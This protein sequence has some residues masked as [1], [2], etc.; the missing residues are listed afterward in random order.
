MSK[1]ELDFKYD[2][3]LAAYN[4]SKSLSFSDGTRKME[5]VGT[6]MEITDGSNKL[7]V[8]SDATNPS[9]ELTNGSNVM[10]VNKTEASLVV[11]TNSLKFVTGNKLKV[12]Y[13]KYNLDISKDKASYSDG[14]YSVNLGGDQLLKLNDKTKTFLV[15]NDQSVEF[16]EGTTTDIKVS[17]TGLDFKY[18]KYKASFSTSK[19]LS[20]TDGTRSFAFAGNK[21]ELKENTKILTLITDATNPSIELSD[22]SNKLKMSKTNAELIYGSNSLKIDKDAKLGIVYNGHNINVDS[23]KASYSKGSLKATVGGGNIVSVSEGNR[24]LTLTKKADIELVDGKYKA[25]LNYS[26][27]SLSLTDGTHTVKAGGKDLL[28]YSQAKYEIAFFKGASS[29]YG[30]RGKYDGTE[31]AV[32]GGKGKKVKVI[33]KNSS[34]GTLAV[35]SNIKKDIIFDYAKGSDDLKIETGS[36]DFKATGSLASKLGIPGGSSANLPKKGPAQKGPKYLKTKITS[37]SAAVVGKVKMHYDSGKDYLLL[38]GAMSG[39]KPVCISGSLVIESKKGNWDVKIGSEK[40]KIEIYP[41]CTGFGGGG[42]LAMNKTSTEIVVFGGFKAGGCVDIG[43]ADIC[44]NASLEI[45]AGVKFTYSPS[46]KFNYAMVAADFR[47]SIT[48]DPP[49]PVSKFTIGAVRLY[50]KL[51]ADFDKDLISGELKGR[52]TILGCSKG[53]DMDF[54][55]GI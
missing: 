51:K 46:F 1:T 49:W 36:K 17:K 55:M 4:T 40:K 33:A 24:S 14:T 52:A 31:L 12:K 23:E 2:K 45:T 7:A 25:A 3:Y 20:F 47:A 54:K 48:V 43:I 6:K 50:G 13:D 30:L 15:N 19:S 11:G 10:K 28:S 34:I 32:E 26:S 29:Q 41:T 53:F 8:E 35:S 9:I 27:K 5:F 42:Y 16:N 22:G 21:V 38:T 18:D 39:Q 37:G 44:A